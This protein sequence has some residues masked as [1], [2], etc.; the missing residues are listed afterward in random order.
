MIPR[1]AIEALGVLGLIGAALVWFGFH[2]ASE[3]KQGAATCVAAVAATAASIAAS[4]A[5]HS[6]TVAATQAEALHE[7]T[8]QNAAHATDARDAAAVVQRLRDDTVRRAASASPAG[9]AS[10]SQPGSVL[11]PPM[12]PWSLYQSALDA[13]AD[14]EQDAIDL[15]GYADCLRTSG[16]LCSAD[17]SGAVKP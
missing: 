2:D 1:W 3:R 6:A 7:F 16:A 5:A 4:D 14:T 13:L 10:G 8:V 15:A 9:A 11:T 12:V 17:Y